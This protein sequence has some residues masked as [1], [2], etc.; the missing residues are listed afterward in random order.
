MMEVPIIQTPVHWFVLQINELVSI[1]YGPPPCISSVYNDSTWLTHFWPMLPFYIPWKYLKT[2]GYKMGAFVRNLL[3]SRVLICS[4]FCSLFVSKTLYGR[5]Y[6][7]LWINSVWYRDFVSIADF[8]TCV[9]TYK[10]IFHG[11][12]K[13]ATNSSRQKHSQTFSRKTL[14]EDKFKPLPT[15]IFFRHL[16]LRRAWKSWEIADEEAKNCLAKNDPFIAQ[17]F[18]AKIKKLHGIKKYLTLDYFPK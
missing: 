6:W 13:N 8:V 12:T 4:L 11:Q 1:W 16:L 3:R 15:N 10:K 5:S 2:K 17:I 9:F 14:A 18:L 7:W